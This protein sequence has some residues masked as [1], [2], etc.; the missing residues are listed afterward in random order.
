MIEQQQQ[1]GLSPYGDLY[2]IIV[3]K[4]NLLRQL[5]DLVDFTF[6]YQKS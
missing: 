1:L 5:K 2:E 3:P 4:N 6:V